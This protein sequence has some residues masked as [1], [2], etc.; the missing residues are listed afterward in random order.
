MQIQLRH[1]RT[2]QILRMTMPVRDRI[3][4][5]KGFRIQIENVGYVIH[6]NICL[7]PVQVKQL[8]QL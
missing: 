4:D 1:I 6:L 7:Q 5:L 8:T 3:T 2:I